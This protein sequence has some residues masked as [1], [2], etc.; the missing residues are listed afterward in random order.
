MRKLAIFSFSFSAAALWCAYAP[1][2]GNPLLLGGI[3]LLLLAAAWIPW[4]RYVRERRAARWAAAGLALGFFWWAGYTAIFWAPAQRLD[5]VT[6]RLQGTVDQWPQEMEYGWSVRVRLEPESGPEIETLLYLDEQ[7]AALGPGDR[8]EMVAHCALADRTVSG[9]RTSYYTAQGIFLT[10]QGYGSLEAERPAVPPLRNWPA[11]WARALEESLDRL[12]PAETAP[13]AKALA[14]GNREDLT[15]GFNADL[16]RTGLSHT[17]AVSGSHLAFLAG[18]LALLLGG[19]RRG[20]ALVLI[21]VSILFTLMAGCTPSIVRAAVMILLLQIAP[22]LGRERDSATAL[23]TALLLLLLWNPFSA[24]NVGLQLSFAAVAGI[25]LCTGRIQAGLTA[26]LPFAGAERGSPGWFIRRALY[27]LAGTLSATV[28]AGVF[29]TPLTALYFN[30]VPLISLLSNLLTLWAVGGLFG[31]SLL[32]GLLGMT[33]LPLAVPLAKL[34]SLLG[35]YLNW[36]IGAL[37]QPAFSAVTLDTFYYRAW[38]VFVYLLVLFTLLQ[39]G[40]RRWIFPACAGVFTLCLTMLFNSLSFWQGAG[41]VTALDV[42]QGQSVLVRS[43]GFT[44]L[45]DCGGDGPENAGDI[46]AGYLGDRGVRRLDLLVL[47][48]FHEDHANGVVQLLRR[49][50]VDRLAIPDVDGENPVRQEILALA[51]ERGTEI[52]YVR[53]DTALTFAD[54]R[55]IRLFAPLGSGETNEE[56]LAFLSS[57]GEFDVLI[58]G[59]MGADVERL[60]LEHTAFPEVEVLAAGHH[61]SKYSTSQALLDQIQPDY[62]LIS[63]G[64]DNRYGHP[65]QGTLERIAASGAQI[66]RTDLSGN[67]TVSLK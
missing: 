18:L 47:T 52:L 6:I 38:L 44:A 50:E 20:T 1:E 35:G 55:T 58:T 2:R 30:S 22:V 62:V 40:K 13:L 26:C 46:A 57:Q 63:V 31:G 7:G 33:P 61:G 21:P 14:T 37:A 42:G 5:D 51:E 10:A 29:T 43:G 36:M 48:H 32:L 39:R 16:R 53:T 17:V 60:L 64:A 66:Y 45:V 28:G 25:L 56:G 8:I 23:G 27:I 4:R 24:A 59:D 34:L 49:M 12:F 41:A 9:E 54:G 15:E 3:F 11:W 19:S 65:A 67:V